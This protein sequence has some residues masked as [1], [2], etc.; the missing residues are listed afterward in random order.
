MSIALNEATIIRPS[1]L[2]PILDWFRHARVA[3]SLPPQHSLPELPDD[4]RAD[5]G[6]KSLDVERTVDRGVAR[7][8]LLDLGWQQPYKPLR[9][10]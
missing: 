5:I 7:L 10:C 3:I 4:V 8:G 9:R 2:R 1:R 6:E